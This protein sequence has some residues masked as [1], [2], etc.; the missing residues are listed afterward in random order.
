[1][2][3]QAP[4]ADGSRTPRQPEDEI[5]G[6]ATSTNPHEPLQERIRTLR[7]WADHLEARLAKKTE[8]ADKW[9]K[10]AEERKER[11]VELQ[12]RLERSTRPRLPALLKGSAR[13]MKLETNEVPSPPR[14]PEPTEEKEPTAA[15]LESRPSRLVH[16]TVRLGVA[17]P[18]SA[19]VPPLLR[20]MNMTI[21]SDSS[22][23]SEIRAVDVLVTVGPEG[24]R[25]AQTAEATVQW[26]RDDNP[27]VAIDSS[28]PGHPSVGMADLTYF[29]EAD[30]VFD[31]EPSSH[32]PEI[33]PH[34]HPT[35]L[36]LSQAPKTEWS[37]WITETLGAA[38]QLD[39]QERRA[40]GL[41]RRLRDGSSAR[42]VGERFLQTSGVTV[43]HWRREA[44]AVLVSKRPD[45]V[46]EATD[47][48]VEQTYRPLRI[49][50]GLHGAAVEAEQVVRQRLADRDIPHMVTS[51]G[52]DIP[53]G[54]CLNALIEES[55]GD[56]VIKIDDDDWYSPVFVTDM[57]G[58][59]EF[60]GAAIV[61]KAAAFVRLRDGRFVLLRT[62]C[63]REVE[64]VVG[65][66]ITAHRWAWET[67]RFPNRYERVDS[68]FLQ[69]ARSAGLRVVSHHPWDF[70]VIR[71]HRGHSWTASDD[72]FLSVGRPVD[73]DWGGIRT[74]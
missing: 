11:I 12:A 61:G 3:E 30:D 21:I 54:A 55:P 26:M 51:F 73:I 57:M 71:H 46:V 15:K 4:S 37:A 31:F 1:M 18:D 35:L 66:T 9:R 7:L 41:L 60:S 32:R 25:L 23:A 16:P 17:A 2:P 19:A 38:S 62:S 28:M 48:M 49:A 33:D 42:V 58:A 65:P 27:T 63:Y 72:Y 64:H 59:L 22:A 39:E 47:R 6:D 45:F 29:D 24:A 70:C 20:R 52:A 50:V 43:P 10:R 53:Q 13:S 69:A 40:A 8:Q 14:Q 5:F 34:L 36:A 68:K 74:G 56:V 67:V 44:L